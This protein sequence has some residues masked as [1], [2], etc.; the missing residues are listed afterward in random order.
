M[1]A[2]AY[3]AEVVFTPTEGKRGSTVSVEVRL[4]KVVGEVR[5]FHL[6]VPGQGFFVT[7]NRLEDRP[8]V[9]AG[10]TLVPWEAPSGTYPIGLYGVDA[11]GNRGPAVYA[12]YKVL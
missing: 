8:D 6:T 7:L 5:K 10:S 12:S 3:Q 2:L 1:E 4:D 11:E 9:F